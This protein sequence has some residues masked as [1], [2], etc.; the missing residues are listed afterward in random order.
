MAMK[1]ELVTK[2]E[3]FPSGEIIKE[4]AKLALPTSQ[5]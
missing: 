2:L 3:N 4:H 1:Q 5:K